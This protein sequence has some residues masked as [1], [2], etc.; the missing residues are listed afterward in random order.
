MRRADR[1]FEILQ[2]LRGGRLRTARALAEA[3]EVST[4]TIWRDIAELQAQ[5]VPIEGERGVGYLLRDNF[6]LPP[7]ALTQAE[8]EALSWGVK[9]VEGF[10]DEA[11][12]AA[13]RELAIKIAAVSPEGQSMAKSGLQVFAAPT[14]RAAKDTLAI[15]RT[16][17]GARRKLEICYR[18]VLGH[19]TQRVV[20]PL[21]LEFWGQVWTLTS[22]CDLRADFR[23][24]RCDR[25]ETCQA[26]PDQF[27][28]EDGKRFSD[29]LARIEDKAAHD[30]QN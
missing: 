26:L 9:L 12:A 18:D 25:L 11:M 6:F 3:L 30:P 7:L 28:D 2:R 10:G 17:I 24:F 16:A 5:G 4:R 21:S 23:V 13:A 29:F 14:A 27:R 8:A 19:Q 22:W 15:I 1:L 20:R